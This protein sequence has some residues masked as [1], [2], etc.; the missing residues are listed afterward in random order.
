MVEGRKVELPGN[1]KVTKNNMKTNT[2]LTG[3]LATAL[4]ALPAVSLADTYHFIDTSGNMQSMEAGSPAEAL[5]TA[6][7]L[8]IHSGVMLIGQGGSNARI[9]MNSTNFG[10]FYHFIDTNGDLQGMW[11]ASASVALATAPH[12]GIHSGV[13]LVQ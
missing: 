3:L 6:P 1:S 5:A 2:M 7:H 11:A 8:G 10:H 4:L 13:M 12:L 9:S